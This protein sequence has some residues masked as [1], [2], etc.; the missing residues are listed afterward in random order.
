MNRFELRALKV[1]NM[2]V[3]LTKPLLLVAALF[4]AFHAG[5]GVITGHIET[6]HAVGELTRVDNPG[7]FWRLVFIYLFGSGF[8]L[9]VLW[10]DRS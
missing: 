7:P 9:Y 5:K 10:K 1:L 3:K 2:F 4:L 8:L 6:G